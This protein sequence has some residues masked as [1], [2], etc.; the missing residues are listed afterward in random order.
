METPSL[1]EPGVKHIL[2]CSLKESRQFKERYT[3]NIFNITMLILFVGVL[4]GFL[5]YR[6]KGKATKEQIASNTR[7]KN[8]YI[9]SKLQ[10]L[11]TI[12]EKRNKD[13]ITNLPSWSDNPEVEMLQR[14][15]G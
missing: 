12:K 3:N 5:I 1:C 9:M 2:S 7:S 8:E 13:M 15:L 14:H 10:R 11:S 4:V 6:Y